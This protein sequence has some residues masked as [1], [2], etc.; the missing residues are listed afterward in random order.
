MPHNIS[1]IT[2]IAA[3]LGF[4]LI[5][6]FIATRMKLPALVG[7]LAAGIVI[8]PATP[9]FV[10]DTAL[11]GQL[12]E[13]GVMLM[14]FGVGLHFSLDDLW[15]V[16]R[17]A[18]PGAILQIGVATAMGMGLAHFW[19]WS[20]GGGLV[21]GLALSV[22]STVVLLRAL[23]ERGILDSLNGRIAVGWLVVEDLVTVLVL[24]LLP[25]LA[26]SL[27]G[28]VDPAH[29][30]ASL[31]RTLAI[32]FGQVAG[33]IVFMLVVGRKLFPWILWQVAR[34]GSRELFTLCVIAA[35]VGIAYG[36][37]QLFGVSFALGAFFAGMVLRESE[38]SHRAAQES[39]P[40]RDAFAV[41]FFVSV[42]MLFE[43]K[44]LIEQPLHVLVVCAIII[45]GK[46]IAAFLLVVALRYPFK[47]A[48]IVSASLAQIGEFS[49]VLAALGI[50]LGLMPH[51]GQSLILAGAILS[52]ALNPL[53]FSATKPL[54][55]W[56]GSGELARKFELQAD[57]LAELPP[58]VDQSKLSGQ[59]VLVGYGR[60]GRS[61][62]E[63]LTARGIHF[64]VA[65][66][67]RDLVDQL[68]KQG[69]PA[70]AGN[71]GEPSV[72]IQA[73]ITHAT[74]LVIA[75]PD[76]F[77]VRAMIDTAR[78]LNPDILSVVRSHS[79]EEAGLLR[80]ELA[81]KV[82]VGERE[83]ANGMARHVIEAFEKGKG[84]AH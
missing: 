13:I 62:A 75:T 5:F 16:R 9:G 27:G 52:I 39:L 35:A 4:G 72:L 42:G 58:T 18:L 71:A 32:T 31:W 24:V 38:L 73:H 70:V 55:R 30:D 44:I 82:F 48:L 61:I 51:E 10:A 14:M 21:F 6:G 41:L 63:T 33:F 29:A 28:N 64:V 79:E 22:A 17:I 50:S 77:H 26:G 19:G 78:A 2:T 80:R 15:D 59:V 36:S 47:T 3:A 83:L 81:G 65:E 45:F 23:E 25:P 74:M 76:T 7:Y 54:L 20:L 34:T 11:A 43:P 67:N 8:G 69:I 1:L 46:S 56:I 84:G 53:L 37:T 12:A 49:F 66:Q 68:R 40:L 60:V 57:P